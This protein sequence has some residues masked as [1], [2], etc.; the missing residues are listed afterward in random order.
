MSVYP[1]AGQAFHRILSTAG[2]AA[3]TKT[4]DLPLHYFPFDRDVISMHRPQVLKELLTDSNPAALDE[5]AMVCIAMNSCPCLTIPTLFVRR[6]LLGTAAAKCSSVPVNHRPIAACDVTLL[7]SSI[8]CS[9]SFCCC[10][11][12]QL[13]WLMQY[14]CVPH[15]S[16]PSTHVQRLEQMST[17][18]NGVA[19][20]AAV[21]RTGCLSD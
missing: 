11:S 12:K 3:C 16:S 18:L 10:Q 5:T 14:M 15:A 19:A 8:T 21:S 4:S 17:S 20:L 7:G 9:L 1:E 13:D 2:E 6:S